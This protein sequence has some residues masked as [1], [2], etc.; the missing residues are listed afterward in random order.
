MNT[1]NRTTGLLAVWVLLAIFASGAFAQPVNMRVSKFDA[2][3][4]RGGDRAFRMKEG[5]KGQQHAQ[6]QAAKMFERA[7][8][9]QGIQ[10]KED[11]AGG[12]IHVNAADPSAHF[13]VNKKTGDFSFHKGMADYLNSQQ[14]PGLLSGDQAVAKAKEHLQALGEL[15]DES[16][17]VVKHVGGLR[18]FE[19]DENGEEKVVDKLTTVYFGRKIGDLEVGGPGSKIIVELGA[20]GGLV[21]VQKRWMALSGGEEKIPPGS[22]RS[23]GEVEQAAQGKMRG[24]F[25][26]AKRIDAESLDL[27][28]YDDGDGN[29]EPAYFTFGE[30]T[31]DGADEQG[32]EGEV[33]TKFL[34]ATAAMKNSKA[35]FDQED[36]PGRQP[37]RGEQ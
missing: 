36:K 11:G 30:M 26:K 1:R 20:N 34:N 31:H 6:G 5:F 29:I 35:K 25:G 3:G 2:P 33:K 28:Y 9:S 7:G 13:R 27:G 4:A 22:L 16:E 21:G 18:M 15:P 12:L 17:L 23:R 32:S 24:E 8:K 37:Q 10:L 14:T 19:A